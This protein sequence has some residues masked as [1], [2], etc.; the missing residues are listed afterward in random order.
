MTATRRQ[1]SGWQ[2]VHG[3]PASHNS[4]VALITYLKRFAGGT[5]V[6]ESQMLINAA[7]ADVE[8]CARDI[9]ATTC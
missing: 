8:R 1:L 5:I 2:R 6:Q 3:G 9:E 7:V 4:L